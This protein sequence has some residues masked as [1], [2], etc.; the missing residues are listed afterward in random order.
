MET[1]DYKRTFTDSKSD[2]DIKY[3]DPQR[4]NFCRVTV[5]D[6]S[7]YFAPF[8]IE[9]EHGYNGCED[10]S[11]KWIMSNLTSNAQV[12]REAIKFLDEYKL[13]EVS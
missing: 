12:V 6:P 9:I 11:R 2:P 5:Y 13:G 3:E 10:W 1:I 7:T 4:D 8:L